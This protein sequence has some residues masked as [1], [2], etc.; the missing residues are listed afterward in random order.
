[1]TDRSEVSKFRFREF[2]VISVSEVVWGGMESAFWN[3]KSCKFFFLFNRKK[4]LDI[5]QWVNFKKTNSTKTDQS[6]SA[7][8]GDF[9]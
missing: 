8:K 2:Y 6:L 3:C 7:G 1:M 9:N 4:L 5:M